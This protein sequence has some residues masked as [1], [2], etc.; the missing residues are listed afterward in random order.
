MNEMSLV[1]HMLSREGEKSRVGASRNEILKAIAISPESKNAEIYFEEVITN[2]A[3][4][5][6]P[7]GLQ[8][9]FNP[10]DDQW[11]I[12]YEKELSNIINANPFKGRPRLAA[13]LFCTLICCIKNSG[14]GKIHQIKEMRKKKSI[15]ED[16]KELV[17]K[18][19]VEIDDSQLQV[20][21]TPLIGYQL[22]LNEL[23]LKLALKLK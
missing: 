18:G 7:L 1:M 21:L 13:T 9:R 20:R 2:V 3:N 4:Y 17:A 12:N 5:I 11:F 16:L 10:I 8:I 19:Y 22:D 6:A 15:V 14:V 23:F